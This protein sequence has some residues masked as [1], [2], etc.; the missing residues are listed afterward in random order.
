MEENSVDLVVGDMNKGV[1]KV[2]VGIRIRCGHL[3]RLGSVF[4][5][6]LP[7]LS[8]PWVAPLI[9]RLRPESHGI[10][11]SSRTPPIINLFRQHPALMPSI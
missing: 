8:L 5:A 7:R 11:S 3:V 6:K 1:D 2:K 10:H 9:H 4:V